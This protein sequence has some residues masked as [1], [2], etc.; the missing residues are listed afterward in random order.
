LAYG[1]PVLFGPK[2]AKFPE[3][4]QF[5]ALGYA[6]EVT[7][8]ASFAHVIAEITAS[9]PNHEGICQALEA[10]CIPISERLIA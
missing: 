8:Q 5:M 9:V 2:H 1:L 10:K 3:A 4:A 6:K 7:S